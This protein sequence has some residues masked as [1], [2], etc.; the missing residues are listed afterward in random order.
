MKSLHNIGMHG[1]MS[2]QMALSVTSQNIANA[3]VPFYSR[4]EVD[5]SDSFN[6]LF[7]SGVNLA[8]V[9]RIYDDALN[10]SIQLSQT[11]FAQSNLYNQNI[12]EFE[13]L[14]DEE[15]YS[16]SNYL[17]ESINALNVI[18]S[19]PASI[20]SRDL[21]LYQ[22]K[23]IVSRFNAIDSE[24]QRKQN[25]LND[26]L[27]ADVSAINELT[28]R[29]A[30]LNGKLGLASGEEREN[31]LDQRDLFLSSLAKYINYDVT[32]GDNDTVNV[33]LN[34]GI[35]LV[36]GT[37]KHNLATIFSPG[38]VST[39]NIV[40]DNNTSQINVT[41]LLTSGEIGGILAYQNTVLQ[42]ARVS[43]D[44]LAMVFS[45]KINSQQKL[46]MDFNGNLGAN[47]FNDINSLDATKKRV[48]S[49]TTNQGSGDLSVV[50]TDPGKLLATDYELTFDN[51][52][53]YKLVRKSDHQLVSQGSI[54]G[55]PASIDIDGFSLKI[56]NGPINGGDIFTVSPTRNAAKDVSL[57]VSSG[58]KLALG[59]PVTTTS[60]TQNLGSG[61]IELSAMTDTS[62]S[63][64]STPGQLSPPVRIEF[65]SA[66][67]YRLVN[68][69]DNS[70]IENNLPYDPLNG[71]TVFPTAGGYDPGFRINLA[72]NIQAGDK[73]DISYNTNGMG[74]NRNGLVLAELYDQGVMDNNTLNFK[75]AYQL[76]SNSISSKANSSQI[77][78]SSH[79]L[80]K[81][82]ALARR[83]QLSGVSLQEETMNIARY[84]QAY[85]ASAQII[86]AGQKIFDI[87]LGLARR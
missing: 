7:G 22:L 45:E 8:G 2:N 51:S 70:I 42:E 11:Q 18:N 37:D 29:L 26:N 84:Q 3:H 61:T 15:T 24:I 40:V 67:S 35:S 27:N 49:N 53:D 21:Y 85:E 80:I 9:R 1:L 71:T 57:I 30:D 41:S 25:G 17:N 62:T 34:N 44:R 83:D 73:F 16:I 82:Q 56:D 14:F 10:R 47:L 86:D 5:F 52:T 66:T 50:I 43:M 77:T 23:N 55:Y 20:Q 87:L 33:Q 78:L 12:K 28:N 39:L 74:D 64:F 54:G 72:G 60:S 79:T 38:E 58:A 63:I 36:N 69:T 81:D 46:G 4:R 6:G 13:K 59:F 76:I 19:N 68:A 75:K 31:L 65:I 32:F 48:I